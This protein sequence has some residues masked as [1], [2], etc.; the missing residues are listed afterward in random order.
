M[1]TV[2]ESVENTERITPI[3]KLSMMAV[4]LYLRSCNVGVMCHVSSCIL[5]A[6]LLEVEHRRVR[7][8]LVTDPGLALAYNWKEE[9][10]I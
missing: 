4:M 3:W 9:D 8:Q 2:A 5:H 6:P 7:G 10:N 1:E